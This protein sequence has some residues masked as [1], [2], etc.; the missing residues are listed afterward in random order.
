MPL[1]RVAAIKAGQSPAS[2]LVS[3]EGHGL[4]F[5]QGNAEFGAIHPTARYFC[6]V[7][8]KRCRRGDVLLSVRAPV[9]ALNIADRSYGIGRGL[10]AITP[11]RLVPRYLWW[12][13]H[14]RVTHLKSVATGSTYDAVSAEDVGSLVMRVP[15]IP[16]QQAIADYLDAETCDIDALLSAEQRRVALAMERVAAL[17]EAWVLGRQ[18]P[19]DVVNEPAGPLVPPPIGWTVRRNKTFLREVVDLSATGDEELLTVSHLTG[20]NRRRDKDV[21]MFLAESNEGYKRVRPG[22]LVINTMWAWMGALGVSA[23][24]G[25][26]SPAYGVYRFSEPEIEPLYFDALFRSR[27]YIAEM[28]RYSRGVW[29]SRL[30]LYPESFLDL[31]SPVPC[32][33]EQRRIADALVELGAERD[34]LIRV[35]E[36]SVEL[37]LER[38]QALITATV[39]GQLKIPGVAA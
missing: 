15:S 4:P 18:L 2:A 26:V 36:R 39:T 32:P 28:T 16:K 31:R 8:P 25:I 10:C 38:R 6:D 20:I 3:D 24:E 21:N 27:A 19:G 13:L 22:D 5:L 23:H 29:T 9:G 37:L 11:G 17:T 33:T 14:E 35:L 34:R 30:R 7:A 1:K 12:A